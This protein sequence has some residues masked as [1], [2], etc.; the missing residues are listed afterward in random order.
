MVHWH[1][2]R[3]L[4]VPVVPTTILVASKECMDW[5]L[6]EAALTLVT[7]ATVASLC[8]R[9]LELF[10]ISLQAH[11]M[12]RQRHELSGYLGINV[13]TDVFFLD[14]RPCW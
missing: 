11:T 10:A 13:Q 6:Y 1:D 2:H 9:V 14:Y 4:R 7:A 12:L 5:I 3:S 8:C